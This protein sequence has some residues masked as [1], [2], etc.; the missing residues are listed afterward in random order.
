MWGFLMEERSLQSIHSLSIIKWSS[1]IELAV[2]LRTGHL[3]M[4]QVS[5]TGQ[6]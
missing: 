3:S 6:D 1:I 2:C 5:A 4:N